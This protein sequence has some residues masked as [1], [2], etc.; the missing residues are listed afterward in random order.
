MLDTNSAMTALLYKGW[1][2]E[3]YWFRGGPV[4]NIWLEVDMPHIRPNVDTCDYVACMRCREQFKSGSDTNSAMTALLYKGW[5]IEPYWFRGGPVSNIWL[6]VDMPHIRPNVDT[7][8]YVAC[9][10]CM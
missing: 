3:P 4:S 6:E 8:D 2:I 5:C 1:C 7:C 9:M 10:R